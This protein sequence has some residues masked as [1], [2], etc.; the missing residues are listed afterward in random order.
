M[1]GALTT[2]EQ[3]SELKPGSSLEEIL[4]Y[5]IRF[6][7]MRV[8]R[9]SE[10]WYANIEMNTNITGATFKIESEFGE[11]TPRQAAQVCIDR[12]HTALE[13]LGC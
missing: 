9:M 1:M 13:N 6:G 3:P 5:S 2:I 4:S 8:S 10:G 11:A 12:M 7:K